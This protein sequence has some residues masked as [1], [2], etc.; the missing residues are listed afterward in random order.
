MMY[1]VTVTN[2]GPSLAANVTATDTLP[3][4]VTFVNGTGPNNEAL[5]EDSGVI[6][7]IGGVLANGESFSF[8]INVTVDSGAPP[9]VVN[10]TSVTTTTTAPISTSRAETNASGFLRGNVIAT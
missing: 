5:V 2:D 7:V 3:T 1:T 4:G 10:T 8:T 9:T 6:T